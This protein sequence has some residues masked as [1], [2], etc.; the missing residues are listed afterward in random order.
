MKEI[1]IYTSKTCGYCKKLKEFFNSKD[2]KFIEK[3]NEDHQDDWLKIQRLTGLST[4]PTTVQGD[5]YYVPGR[6]YN[7]PEQ[8]LSL[9]NNNYTE[10]FSVE[11][12]S[13]QAMKTLIYSIN[14]GF[15]R[16]ITEINKLKNEHKS[17][18]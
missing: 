10:E 16:L 1:T 18:N 12:R 11:L 15:G 4:W 5:N 14:Q 2:I 7:N 6:D 9:L 13:E 8:L 17:T 3:N